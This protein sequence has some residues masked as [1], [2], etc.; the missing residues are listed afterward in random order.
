MIRNLKFFKETYLSVLNTVAP[1]KIW[2]IPANQAPFTKKEIEGAVMVKSK[3][4]K[5]CFKSKSVSDKK[6]TI[7]KEINI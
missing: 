1:L 4:R 5:K 3:L 6:Q 7:N 2:F